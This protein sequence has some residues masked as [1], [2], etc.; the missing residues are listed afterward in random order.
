MAGSAELIRN[1]RG[2]ALLSY[3]FRP[4]FLFGAI[5][6]A[7]TMA[8]WPAVLGGSIALPTAFDPVR[9]HAHELIYGYVPAVISGFLLTAV[10]NWTGRLPI[11]GAKLLALFALWAAGRAAVMFSGLI[12]AA[13][14]AAVDLLFLAALGATVAREIVA[15]RSTRNLKVLV[16]LTV[17]L[18]GNAISHAE[19]LYSARSSYGLYV[20]LAAILMLIILIG[21]R[22]I[23]SFTRNWLVRQGPGH[24]PRPFDHFDQLAVAISAAALAMWIAAPMAVVT[25]GITASAAGAHVWRL[26]RWAGERSGSEPLVAILHI[27]YGFVPAGFALLSMS[28]IRPDIVP[29][30]AAIHAWTAGAIGTMTLAVMTRASLGHTDRPLIATL[31]I[32]S[33]Y[34]AV[35]FSAVTRVLAGLGMARDPMLHLSAA[36]WVFAFAGFVAVFGPVLAA[37]RTAAP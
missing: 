11:V 13:L 5:W 18:A 35:I 6:A 21:G 25:A 9:W 4:F 32:Q 33:I 8:I 28:I 15:G 19:L 1:F 24:L 10:P 12:G 22:I 26:G 31:A 17:L 27:G 3:G 20:G 34:V 7:A 2:P 36:A 16:L 14:A 37:R 29:A 23:P 30:S